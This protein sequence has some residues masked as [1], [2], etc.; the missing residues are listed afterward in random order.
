VLVFT[1]TTTVRYDIWMW[2]R[3]GQPRPLVATPAHELSAR[4]SADGRWL[5]YQSD[6]SGR[7][8]IY[9]RPFPN[10]D[11]GKWL[12]S[13][14]GGVSPVW[15]PSGR[16]LYYLNGSA[17]MAVPIRPAAGAALELGLPAP[18][19]DG[20]FFAGT[21]N[22]DVSPD[23]TSFIMIESDPSARHTQVEVVLNWAED[24]RR[25]LPLR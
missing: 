7:P 16:E 11:D 15:A 24:I 9:I 3:G 20:P 25:L 17:M 1:D 22:F 18:L 23:G 14:G 10:V 8:E 21:F 13:R 12:V 5:A 4:L 6:E 2:P 19:F